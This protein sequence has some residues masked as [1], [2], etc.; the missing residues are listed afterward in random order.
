MRKLIGFILL[1]IS[2]A[3]II[4]GSIMLIDEKSYLI[5]FTN[6]ENPIQYEIVKGGYIQ[7]PIEP[8][9]QGYR[10]IGWYHNGSIFNFNTPIVEDIKLEAKWEKIS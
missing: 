7:M 3:M 1:I 5:Q 2:I 4:T 9:K 6:V 10:F 8:T